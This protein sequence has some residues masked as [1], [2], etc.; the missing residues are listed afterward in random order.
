MS[1][2]E[3]IFLAFFVVVGSALTY[4]VKYLKGVA[5]VGNALSFFGAVATLIPAL[6]QLKTNRAFAKISVL[7]V[8]PGLEVIDE[9]VESVRKEE[10]MSFKLLDYVLFLGG[11]SL[12]CVG[13][14][15]RPP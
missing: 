7:P 13:F 3:K 12:V 2:R 15:V 11:I 4:Y 5:Q 1:A 10:F 8:P 14:L 6:T 9:A